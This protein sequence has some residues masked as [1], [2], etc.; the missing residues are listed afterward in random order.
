MLKPDGLPLSLYHALPLRLRR[1]VPAGWKG[2]WR[3]RLVAPRTEEGAGPTRGL[4]SKL[5]GGFSRSAL[6]ELERIR[7][8]PASEPKDA[9][10]AAWILA[11]WAATRGDYA[12]ALEN[13]VLMRLADPATLGD[14]RQVLQEAKY[15]CLLGRTAQARALLDARTRDEPF[16]PSV[17]LMRAST[18]AMAGGEA[19]PDKAP[20]EAATLAEINTV[21]RHFGLAEIAKRDP[22]RP[23]SL[24]NLAAAPLPAVGGPRV[25]VIVPAYNAERTLATALAGLAAQSWEN[26]EVLVVDD[27]SPDGTAEVAADFAARDRRFRLIRQPGNGGSYACRNRA[28]AEATG[29]LVT[30]HDADDW[31]HPEKL[32]IQAEAIVR[33]GAPYSFTAWTRTLP[34]L[35]F[36]GIAQA[37]RSLVS[38]NFSS[39]MIG[40]DALV[41]AGG[42]DHVRVTGDS[43]LI[44]RIEAL[45]GRRKD[46]FRD[47]LLLPTC[48]L[49]FGRLGGTSLTG[50]EATH[51]LSIY[52]GVR[53]EYREA[54]DH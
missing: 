53:R 34:E 11:R 14:R 25:T 8:S 13:I 24:D 52:H 29:E 6:A 35:V 40:R 21:Y 51:V 15:L 41:A 9:A 28:L 19:A 3:R 43:E 38:L 44:W 26:L 42:W 4:Q 22:G 18:Y 32:R 31:S 23:L 5:W 30:V 27:A 10:R 7:L 49:A 33:G 36:L 45:A 2:R 48:P 50:S 17:A 20:D 39:Q 47:H 1:A 46:A 16:D 12:A 37:T 54:A